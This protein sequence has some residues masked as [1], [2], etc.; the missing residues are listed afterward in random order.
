M[1]SRL[2]IWGSNGQAK[3]LS[4]I[5]ISNGGEIIAFIEF[6]N[7]TRDKTD[8]G[9]ILD[10][11]GNIGSDRQKLGAKAQSNGFSLPTLIRK[12]AVVSPSVVIGYGSQILANCCIASQAVIDDYC[13]VNNSANIDHECNLFRGV[14]IALGAVLCG[15]VRVGKNS[16]IGVG[17]VV[18]P[19]IPIGSNVVIGAGCN[20]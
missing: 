2:V 19:R 20:C 3:V 12:S 16:I 13:I 8:L 6:I 1:T 14:Q 7:D 17:A 9:M 15:C 4:D 11:G 5:I 18:L 10:F